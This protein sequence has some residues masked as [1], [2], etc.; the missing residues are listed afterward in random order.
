[1]SNVV[2]VPS[3]RVP[4]SLYTAQIQNGLKAFKH[5]KSIETVRVLADAVPGVPTWVA[6]PIRTKSGIAF[7]AVSTNWEAPKPAIERNERLL[8]G[9]DAIVVLGEVLT[10]SAKHSLARAFYHVKG[11]HVVQVIGEDV[12]IVG[13]KTI[14][15]APGYEIPEPKAERPSEDTGWAQFAAPPTK[16]PA[17]KK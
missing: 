6:N 11:C 15:T 8:A 10:S 2:V 3:P 4:V 14:V 17:K 13:A 9:V 1:M 12:K 7:E 5:V 16:A